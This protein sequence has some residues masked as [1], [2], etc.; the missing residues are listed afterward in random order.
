MF[1]FSFSNG[2]YVFNM[3]QRKKQVLFPNQISYLFFY[4]DSCL[5]ES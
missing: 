4:S 5:A 2:E 1:W 3:G